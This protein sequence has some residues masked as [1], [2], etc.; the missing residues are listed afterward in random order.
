MSFQKAVQRQYVQGFVGEIAA[1][2]PTRARTGIITAPATATNV[3]R[4]GRAFGYSA[5]L[6][7]MGAGAVTPATGAIVQLGGSTYYGVLGT[8]KDHALYGDA[9]G[10]LGASYDLPTGT[11]AQFFTMAIM[12]LSVANGSDTT[13]TV[14]F[15]A[16]MYY[17]IAAGA[18][19][20][21]YVATTASDVGRLY[22]FGDPANQ[23]PSAA[24]WLPMGMATTSTMVT[25]VVAAT[26]NTTTNLDAG[27][28]SVRVQM[29]R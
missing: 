4:I 24:K 22:V 23:V 10:P 9:S 15:G 17:C 29:T 28:V 3:N 5:G 2:G 6:P 20:A 1:D 8:P 12:T 21:G 13:Q 16:Q 25:A 26:P 7:A 18:A 14:P 27:N 19:A 11:T